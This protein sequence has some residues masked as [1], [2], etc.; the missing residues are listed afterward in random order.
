MA[1]EGRFVYCFSQGIKNLTESFDSIEEAKSALGF[2][3]GDSPG[4]LDTEEKIVYTHQFT[5]DWWSEP[6]VRN[7]FTDYG[8]DVSDWQIE[9]VDVP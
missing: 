5:I 8:F 1:K 2:N 6:I 9:V 4:F 7:M 3:F